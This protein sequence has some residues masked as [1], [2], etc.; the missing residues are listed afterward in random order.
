[1]PSDIV[2]ITLHLAPA[3]TPQW[4][5]C[6][7]LEYGGLKATIHEGL[8]ETPHRYSWVVEVAGAN[9]HPIQEGCEDSLEAAKS[10]AMRYIRYQLDGWPMAS[11]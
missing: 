4:R 11:G 9:L 2:N 5:G 8:D 7:I 1:M 3:S 6:H 10:A